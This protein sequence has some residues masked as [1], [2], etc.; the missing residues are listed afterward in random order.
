[1]KPNITFKRSWF[2]RHTNSNLVTIQSCEAKHKTQTQES[3]SVAS[4]DATAT[5]RCDF[6]LYAYDKNGRVRS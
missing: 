4:A 5:Y 1:M 2:C 3:P 6:Y